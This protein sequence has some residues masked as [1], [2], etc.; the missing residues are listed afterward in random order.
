MTLLGGGIALIRVWSD[1]Y[2]HLFISLGAGVF[3][4]TVFV[5]LLPEALELESEY[6]SGLVLLIGYLVVFFLERVLNL[7]SKEGQDHGHRIVSITVFVG[8]SVHSLIEGMGLTVGMQNE[9]IGQ[10]I[11]ISILAHKIP[12]AFALGCLFMLAKMSRAKVG[13]AILLFSLMTPLG[14][15]LFVP[16]ASAASSEAVAIMTGLTA[17]SFLYVATGDLLPEVFHTRENRWLKLSLL[18][19]GVALVALL[20]YWAG[21]EIG[22][23]HGH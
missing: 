16:L 3:L 23:G 19:A 4:G 7:V 21:P 13:G 2:L 15:A 12:A 9:G 6:D 1:E 18:V 20:S 14:A 22:H 5:H 17:G 11:L 10:V 8:L